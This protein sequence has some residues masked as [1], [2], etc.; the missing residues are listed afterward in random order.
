M[1]QHDWLDKDF[2][3]I[4]GVSS[5]VTDKDLTKAYRKLARKFHPDANPD[6][7]QAEDRF[8]AVSEAYD[9][10]SDPVRRKEYDEVRRF[11]RAGAGFGPSGR[12]PGG[13]GGGFTFTE[14]GDLSDLLGGIFGGNRRR[15]GPAPGTG[16]RRGDDLEAELHLSF[17]EAI[18]GVTTSVHLTGGPGRHVTADL[19]PLRGPGC[20]R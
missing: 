11:G 2:Y 5:D 14:S 15:G 3:Q 20:H 19:R 7:P 12:S 6:D 1:A 13:P 18:E 17:D 10:L 16:P 9:V 8:K 4:L